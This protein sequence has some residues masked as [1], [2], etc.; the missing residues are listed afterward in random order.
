VYVLNKTIMAPKVE[1]ILGERGVDTGS[2]NVEKARK[3][4]DR[5]NL[6]VEQMQKDKATLLKE[7]QGLENDPEWRFAFE[8][9]AP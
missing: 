4:I 3:F 5:H 8:G 7:F 1:D 2:R 6:V 9:L